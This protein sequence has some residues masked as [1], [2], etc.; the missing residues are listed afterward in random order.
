[1]RSIDDALRSIVAKASSI[2]ERLT[3]DF[4]PVIDD[5]QH[6]I[7]AS[8]MQKW[9]RVVAKNDAATFQRRLAWDR[10]DEPAARRAVSSVQIAPGTPLPAWAVTLAEVLR[11]A[12]GQAGDRCLAAGEPIPFEDIFIPFV[13]WARTAC[14]RRAE[15]T[16]SR[17]SENAHVTL[18]RQLLDWL[19]WHAVRPLMLEL[20]VLL[21]DQ[22]S[23]LDD[24][25]QEGPS[26]AGYRSFVESMLNGGLLPFFEEYSALAR[27]LSTTV[28]N[29]VDATVELLERFSQDRGAIGELVGARG[30]LNVADLSTS[31]SDPH[32]GLRNVSIL[33]LNSGHR[34]V[35]K[36][37]SLRVELAW[38]ALLAGSESLGAP[39]RLRSFRI[40]DRGD[41]AWT[42]FVAY[43]PCQDQVEAQRYYERAGAIVALVY[44][45][46]GTDCHG[47]NVIAA[48]EYPIVIDLETLLCPETPAPQWGGEATRLAAKRLSQSVLSTYLLPLWSRPIG[49]GQV[50]DGSGFG[51]DIDQ[52]RALTV[53]R[54]LFPNTDQ[55]KRVTVPLDSSPSPRAAMAGG[56]PLQVSDYETE[57]VH[58]F[59]STY[60]WLIRERKVLLSDKSPLRQLA[61]VRARFV[62][63]KTSTYGAIQ[64]R[65]NQPDL[66]R[67]G[68][69]RSIE[70]EQLAVAAL[71]GEAA[72]GRAGWRDIWR[73]ERNSIEGGDIPYFSVIAN[74]NQ[75]LLDR[76]EQ[77]FDWF[78]QSGYAASLVLL[79]SLNEDDLAF[80]TDLIRS[81]LQSR[82]LDSETVVRTPVPR[83]LGKSS[84]PFVDEAL[85]IS[86]VILRS[87]VSGS[88]GTLAWMQPA[89]SRQFAAEDPNRELDIAGYD[90]YEGASG[91]GLFFAAAHRVTERPELRSAAIASVLPVVLDLEH[92]D[93]MFHLGIGGLS[94]IGSI[95]YG[96]SS[97]SQLLD[98]P[99]LLH[100]AR[101]AAALISRER[102]DMDAAND[103]TLG[104]AGAAL[105]LLALYTIDADQAALKR[106]EYC[107]AKLVANLRSNSGR[108]SI[109]TAG[110]QDLTG[111][112]HGA[113]G[114]AYALVRLHAMTSQPDLLE[115]ARALVNFERGTFSEEHGDWPDLRRSEAPHFTRAWCHGAPGIALARIATLEAFN[116]LET[117]REI[118]IALKLTGREDQQRGDFLCCG[119][120]GVLN[121]LWT[122][123]RS[124][125]RPELCDRAISI[126][127]QTVER[128][129][130]GGGYLLGLQ[131]AGQLRYCGLFQGLAG[132]GYTLLRLARPDL[133][134]DVLL[135]TT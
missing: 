31:L 58:G 85:A 83:S 109:P 52:E 100:A 101:R 53:R 44:L 23:V 76:D 33:T 75:L 122:A 111:F 24:L 60:R 51:A 106:A 99:R 61:Q 116:D 105:G 92:G 10:I 56:A 87:A 119:N 103:V 132:I 17:F 27:V 82:R 34:I 115:A 78:P 74:E 98:E 59:Q 4:I 30:E 43:S 126:A 70:I 71:V 26:R 68:A 13:V 19:S 15:Q 20:A 121:V 14:A 21:S 84:D 47:D 63:R 129:A 120:F 42:E 40:L 118:D 130:N 95:V 108:R 110:G 36:P 93:T 97:M 28:M 102:I 65:L 113:A 7:V 86:N 37:R 72:D 69:D 45:L 134:P 41:Y 107:G 9:M 77:V 48:G 62:Y 32:R 94:G 12:A 114:M 25:G 79:Q 128:A 22:E 2:H 123:G 18:E 73:A 46:R 16:Y 80:Q 64:D 35:Y 50:I 49:N 131:P 125:S 54:W 133:V 11:I 91:I 8:R 135:L 3:P 38:N 81:S 104:A 66:L 117:R 57:L 90:L 88:D 96:L 127:N 1:M 112:S 39:I 55:M 67:D 89:P 5:S 29:W 6:D 124:L